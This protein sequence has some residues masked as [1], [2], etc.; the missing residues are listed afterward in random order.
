MIPGI[1]ALVFV[2]TVNLFAYAA[3]TVIAW[4]NR[5]KPGVW[6]F[7]LGALCMIGFSAADIVVL[8]TDRVALVEQIQVVTT[9]LA[10][11]ATAT[12]VLF[13]LG[14]LGYTADVSARQQAAV[15]IVIVG[16]P[17][18]LALL[19]GVYVDPGVAPL[20]GTVSS[21]PSY[22]AVGS[23]VL[24]TTLVSLLLGS[25]LLVRAA[26]VQR[27]VPV[28]TALVLAVPALVFLL[29]ATVGFTGLVPPTLPLPRLAGPVA[30]LAYVYFFARADGLSV[31]PA[32]GRTGVARAFDRLD[33][34][35][36]VVET[37]SVILCNPAAAR[38]LGLDGPR[39]AHGHPVRAV[40]G[41]FLDGPLDAAA[42]ADDPFGEGALGEASSATAPLVTVERDGRAYEVTRSRIHSTGYVLLIQDVT[43]RRERQA[44][45]RQNEQLERLAQVVS[46]DFQT[47]LST[48][49]KLTTLLRLDGVEPGSAADRTL[50]DL[51]AVH[52]RLRAF[53][54]HLP[55]L[56][57]E[58]TAVGDPVACEL[59]GVARA[60]W[61]VVETGPLTLE[62]DASRVLYG[63][64]A[65]LEQA[66]QN[67]F[68]NVVVH[69]NVD[70]TDAGVAF[71]SGAAETRAQTVTVGCL[72]SGFYVA[73]DGPGFRETQGEELFDY[74]MSTG[75][76]SGLGL[77]IVR[78][79]VEAHGWT[80]TATESASGGARFDVRVDAGPSG[81]A[82]LVAAE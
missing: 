33:A 53:A 32:T 42:G 63:D 5:H 7:V 69:G 50:D 58:S 62:I 75:S 66:F 60:A 40:L 8:S 23:V 16:V 22:D 57:R 19:P 35:V 13:V 14:Y 56:A 65:R 29:A 6:Y 24:L 76:G 44:L 27:V 25:L 15:G 37:G 20:F 71:A 55:T 1:Q 47:P 43:A 61:D 77:A 80:V 45:R 68:E 48:A 11:A 3:V 10:P 21:D 31:L 38:Y 51:E 41:D 30:A 70:I 12:W 72:E 64:P 49:S 67:L 26:L 34:G 79:I 4:W 74:G 2:L 18:T 82:D 9:G 52:D 81:A 46:H 73:D 59:A 39:A 17:L 54:D 78:T 36:V 28:G